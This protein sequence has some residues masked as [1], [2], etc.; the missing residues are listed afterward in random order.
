M[1]PRDISDAKDPDVRSSLTA[2]RRAAA[3]ARKEAIQTNTD[4]VVVKDGQ[5]EVIDANTLRQEAEKQK[6]PTT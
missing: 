1:N 2:L 3:L 5:I 4:I 6:A